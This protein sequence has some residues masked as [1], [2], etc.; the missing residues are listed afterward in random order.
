MGIIRFNYERPNI[1]KAYG[2][3]SS[4]V[5]RF[6]NHLGAN[7]PA[8]NVVERTDDFE[9]QLAAP[10]YNKE[11][12]KIHVDN[13]ILTISSQKQEEKQEDKV[14]KY[15]QREFNY[16]SWE[17]KFTLPKLVEGENIKATY[18]NGVLR[19]VVPKKEEA[20]P[21]QPRSIEVK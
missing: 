2:R 21:K 14:R 11:D 1:A 19:L 16:T 9:I 17:R 18:E 7:L 8:V 10:G 6:T 5:F 15:I 13:N 3:D 4:D 20:K 12:F